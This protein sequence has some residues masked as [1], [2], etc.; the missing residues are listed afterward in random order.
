PS[1]RGAE[2]AA[3]P[4]DAPSRHGS[5]HSR[6]RDEQ[7]VRFHYDV[8]N[9]FYRL[10]LDRRMVYSCAYFADPG[11]SLDRAQEAK[12]DLVCRKLELR[13]GQRLL[14]IG[15]GWGGLVLHAAARYG[16]NAVGITLSPSQA[17]LAR[18]RIREAG[19]EDRCEVRVAD[20]RQMGRDERFDRIA[21]VGMVE[22]VGR[23]AL[24]RYFAEAFRLLAPGGLFMNHGIVSLE[25]PLG[26]VRRGLRRLRRRT[27]SFIEGYVFPDAELMPPTEVLE[28][29]ERQGFEVRD[30]E[31]LREHYA[32]TLRHWVRRLEAR[33]DQA[34]ALVGEPTYRVWRL[35]MA[36][37]A[38]LFQTARLGVI[39]T[40]LARP[41]EEGA[42]R[43]APHRGHHLPE[44]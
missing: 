41:T 5:L 13:P 2:V 14:D 1:S 27:T 15:C 23:R 18:Q 33:A 12:L 7:A 21:S 35:Y 6:H 22:H 24:P 20:Y 19:L 10:W 36:A 34:I 44:V 28:P 16:V 3:T 8:G 39:Q 26:R 32:R 9:E 38:R 30:V 25:E 31:S 37:S 17:E 43:I 4:R 42:V 11:W 29:A 40:L